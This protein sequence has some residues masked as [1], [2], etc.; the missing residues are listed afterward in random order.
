MVRSQASVFLTDVV[1]DKNGDQELID[2]LFLGDEIH[3]ETCATITTTCN[4]AK[5][6]QC[7]AACTCS[8]D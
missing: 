3:P 1:E 6:T 8:F 7:T 2:N 5:L 4:F